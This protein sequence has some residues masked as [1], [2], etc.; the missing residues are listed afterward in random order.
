[1]QKKTP[2]DELI[3]LILAHILCMTRW[4]DV[5]NLPHTRCLYSIHVL[6]M[7]LYLYQAHLNREM[8]TGEKVNY[9][10]EMCDVYCCIQDMVWLL[11]IVIYINKEFFLR[12]TIFYYGV[13]VY[14]SMIKKS[15]HGFFSRGSN[16]QVMHF[17]FFGKE[18]CNLYV[19][20]EQIDFYYILHTFVL[21]ALLLLSTQ[22]TH[23]FTS[24]GITNR[25][26]RALWIIPLVHSSDEITEDCLSGVWHF[27]S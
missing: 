12:E 10:K 24:F 15:S 6:A 23:H 27:A 22:A 9:N 11:R 8:G 5:C 20:W 3:R 13:Q 4:R 21:Y 14:H 26:R 18:K 1:M 7:G 2:P 19:E 25:C 17:P 16:G